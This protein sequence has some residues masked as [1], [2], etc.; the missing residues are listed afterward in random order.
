MGLSIKGG[1]SGSV[2]RLKKEMEKSS[3]N[4]TWIRNLKQGEDLT[5]RFVEEPED[6]YSYR[7]HYSPEVNFFP[8]IGDDCPGCNSDSDKTQR[9]SRRFLASALDTDQGQVVPLKLPLDLANRLVAR[10]ERY[11]NTITDRDYTLHRMG[12]GLDTSY[13][14]TPEAPQDM[15]LSRYESIDH[16][17]VLLQ[18]FQDAFGLDDDDDKPKSSGKTLD[19]GSTSSVQEDDDDDLDTEDDSLPSESSGTAE[20]GESDDEYLTE[21]EALK[22]SRSEL[23]ALADEIGVTLK[24]N[25]NKQQMVDAIFDAASD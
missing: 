15:D 16:E 6:W 2:D 12:K 19:G 25:W 20:E 24:T 21:E 9:A 17:E 8:C 11:G 22:M 14:V 10:Y 4:R 18:Q 7:E 1:K 5:V 23:K 3:G 13:D